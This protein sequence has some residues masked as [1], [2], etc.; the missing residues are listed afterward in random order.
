MN[1]WSLPHAIL[2]MIPEAWQNHEQMDAS[3]KAFYQFHA[4]LMEPWDGPASIATT[5]GTV[6]AAV[7]DRNG[8]RPSRYYVTKDDMVVF[9][10]EVGV[11]D[12][13]PDNI[14]KKG[15]LE[16]G[17]IFLIDTAK[18][19]IIGDDEIK[20]DL[21]SAKPYKDWVENNQIRF[22]DLPE[23]ESLGKE[24]AVHLR[25]RMQAFGYTTDEL[26]KIMAP[27]TTTGQE[28]IGSMGD[29]T[30]LAVLSDKPK[31]LYNYF[32]QLFAQV[33][34]PP[35]DAIR[36][37]IVTS[38]KTSLGRMGDIL[39][40]GPES[41]HQI[42]LESPIISN[43]EM[44]R[45]RNLNFRGFKSVT[46][47]ML[48]RVK[49]DGKGL[50]ASLQTMFE[51]VAAQIRKGVNVIILSDRSINSQMAP[52][53]S[54]LAVSGLH[55]YLVR[56]ELRTQ[57]SIVVESGD[58]RNTHHFALL[59]GFGATVIN[60]Y[61]AIDA[62]SDM[63]ERKLIEGVDQ[64]KAIYNYL[65]ASVGGVIKTL[66]KMGISTVQS[67]RGAQIFEAL[68]LKTE[69]VDK[70]FERTVSRIQGVGLDVISQEVELRHERAFDERFLAD[71]SLTDGGFYQYRK[72]GEHHLFNPLSIHLL[73]KSTRLGDYAAFKQY[74]TTINDQSKKLATIRGL[75]QFK[76]V[77]ASIPLD[78]VESIESIVKR[79]KTGAMSYG[80]ISS[81]AHET[82]AIAM[83]RLGGKSNSGE[84]GEDPAR[85]IPMANGDSK[86]SAIKQVASGRFGVSSHYLVN[87][88]EIQIKMA[89][90]AKPGEGGQLPGSK[91]YPWVGKVRGTTPGVQLI[92]PPPHHD[93]YSIEDLAQLIFDLKNSNDQARISVKLVSEVGVGTV[94]AGVA[95]GHAD[96]VL[97]SGFDGGTG[98]SPQS[99][100]KH[101]G[102]PWEL[103]LAETHQTLV[104][105]NLRSR[106]VVEADGQMKTGRDV[107]IAA[108]LGAE[109]FGFATAPLVVMGC[110]MMRVCHLNTCPVGVATQDPRLRAKFSG[111]VE[112]LVNF[113]QFIAAEMREI[114][115]D[116]GFRTIEEMVGHT[117]CLESRDVQNH[118]KAKGL[119]LSAILAQPQMGPE[120]G[121]FCTKAQEH[122][123]E[124]TLDSRVLLDLCKPALEKGEKVSANVDVCN[125]DRAIG[126]M[127][128]SR[129]SR[130]YGALGLPEDTIQLRFKGS[131]GQTFG[132]FAPKGMTLVLEGDANDYFGKGL[133]GAKVAVFPP[134]ESTFVAEDN[135][136]IGNVA[137]FGATGG[138]AFVNG[139]AGERFCV[140]NS[141]V[142]AVVEG[143]GDH[144]CEYMTGGRVVILGRTGRNFAAGMSGGIAYIYDVEGKFDKLCNKGMVGLESCTDADMAY[145]KSM[146]EKHQGLTGSKVA[147]KVLADWNNAQQ[148]FVK[149]MPTE[150][151]KILE[152]FDKVRAEGKA[153][154]ED[155][156]ALAAFQ[157]SLK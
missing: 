12:I 147:G 104:L 18:G 46:I 68:G 36:E 20:A 1:G 88:K 107:A 155:E 135:M 67:Y 105:N 47:P 70:Y 45:L 98:A 149:V 151:K 17:R 21:A 138:Q 86:S 106:I 24:D 2:M 111:T 69:V 93:I 56:E 125:R 75:F 94:A 22:S 19:R 126:T 30:P 115:A 40:P 7:L 114:M 8:L 134:K 37:K 150:Y 6:V 52:I 42:S 16:P 84:G 85:F 73:Q 72:A 33:T 51:A 23:G 3:R 157:L 116:L 79:F 143:V 76:K 148:C 65:Y 44:D 34:N 99:S 109:E 118:W 100:I 80:S 119:D 11:L 108:L 55:H 28:A 113:F 140:R 139:L 57:A 129:I 83:N 89:Q 15:R 60:P 71:Q 92:S 101:A 102:L 124:K 66:S 35:I 62:I 54:L 64:E 136:I 41:A 153:Q 121:R 87:A 9:A 131:A 123:L 26:R 38:S 13:A 48:Y 154:G 122:G 144:G 43:S 141:G 130:K 103:G 120:V 110:V 78:Q 127:T 53:P 49:D 96:V 61:L 10:S 39:N 63:I 95:K 117:E 82:M 32:R 145:I 156:T 146:V 132:G 128:G 14:V 90:G 112:A 77:R 74:A 25:Q 137:F 27:M 142:E 59:I 31:L 91:V 4:S 97:I 81:E 152:C 29:D 50:E 5:D 133:S 58:A